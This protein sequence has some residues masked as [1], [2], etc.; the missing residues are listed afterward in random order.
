[1]SA[2]FS[3]TRLTAAVC[4][5][6]C[7]AVAASLSACGSSSSSSSG[8]GK[9]PPEVS[10][11][12][13]KSG[14]GAV[15]TPQPPDPDGVMASLP[16]IYKDNYA[17]YV[18]AVRKSPW[19][20]FKPDHPPPYKVAMAFAQLTTPSQVV[21]YNE[22]KKQFS[23][24]SDYEFVGTTTGNQLNVPQQIQQA[25]SLLQQKPDLLL[26]EPLTDAFGPV[27]DKAAKMGI[28][29]ISIQGTTDSKYAVNVQSNDFGSAAFTASAV[30]RQA[31]GKGNAMY[32][33]AIASTS[34]DADS[35]KAAT[36]VIKSCPGLKLVGETA[37]AFVPATAKAETLKYLATHP[38]PVD[39]VFQTAGMA[40]GIIGAFEQAGRPVPPVMD[41]GVLK[42]SMGYWINN[43]D[44]YNST[45][46][47]FQ[48]TQISDG[49][50]DIGKRILAGRGIKVSNV[51]F[52]L[53]PVTKS[54]LSKWADPNWDINT[55]G[56][57]DGPVNMTLTPEYLSGLFND[58]APAE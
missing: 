46:A 57:A 9:A 51:A 17:G 19:A 14:C 24:D 48:A 44:T 25:Q 20:S 18:P 6:A 32:V 58:P 22:I 11:A 4:S 7:I 23:N 10:T 26:V 50:V 56:L 40:P 45:G 47:A 34:I 52:M 16:Q 39:V 5:M 21:M 36:T 13:P 49:I 27:T 55:P 28:P 54:N 2:Q 3:R 35:Y 12:I 42:G 37:G 29:V 15:A 31:E 53:K 8:A 30:A 33:H 38:G 43:P 41:I 1:M